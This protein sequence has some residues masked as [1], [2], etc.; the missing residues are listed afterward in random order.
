MLITNTRYTEIT[1]APAPANFTSIQADV[2]ARLEDLL[3][4]K[5][6]L[7]ERTERVVSN[8]DGLFYPAATP[9]VEVEEDYLFDDVSVQVGRP[10]IRSFSFGNIHGL[11]PEFLTYTG[12]YTTETLPYGLAHAIAW[13]INTV[14]SSLNGPSGGAPSGVSSLSIAGEYS[15]TFSE[16][17][18]AGADGQPMPIRFAHMFELGGRCVMSALRYRRV[19]V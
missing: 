19:P 1:G 18:T 7:N 6:I 12:G 15:V 11:T 2:I 13:G 14:T 9:I 5:L 8:Y 3:N 4:R 16:G 10:H 17:M